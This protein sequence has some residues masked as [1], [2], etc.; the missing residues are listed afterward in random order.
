MRDEILGCAAARTDRGDTGRH[1][2]VLAFFG[3]TDPAGAARSGP[4]AGRHRAAFDATVVAATRRSRPRSRPFRSAG[5]S[6]SVDRCRS[7]DLT[8]PGG[9]A[10]LWSCAAGTSVW[11]LLCVGAAAAVIWVA[12]NQAAG[13]RAGRSRPG[14]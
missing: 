3:G 2:V 10:D 11:E 6:A 13:V 4:R 14:R 8:A 1:A 9:A 12:D 7:A 5:V